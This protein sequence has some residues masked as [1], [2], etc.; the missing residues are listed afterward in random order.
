MRNREFGWQKTLRILVCLLGWFGAATA[1]SANDNP[2]AVSA[3]QGSKTVAAS[4][5]TV[6]PLRFRRQIDLWS[7]RKVFSPLVP[8]CSLAISPNPRRRVEPNYV[9]ARGD[10]VSVFAWGRSSSTS[11][12]PLML[13]KHLSARNWSGK[14]G[15]CTQC[16]SFARSTHQ[17]QDVYI[18]NFNVYTNLVTT[19]PVLVYVTG[20]VRHPGRYAGL[21][22]DTLLYYLDLAGGI[23]TDLGSY[24]RIEIVRDGHVLANVDLYDFLLNGGIPRVTL[25]EGDTILVKETWSSNRAG[26]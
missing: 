13:K 19:Q 15:G 24:R 5:P 8:I 2:T 16:G 20:F 12:L 18:N 26:R 25:R 3:P 22:N 17:D 11:C 1:M 4:E 10:Q 9:V 21:P 14:A 23:D 7:M 6:Q